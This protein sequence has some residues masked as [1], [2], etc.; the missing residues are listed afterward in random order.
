M[1]GEGEQR[2]WVKSGARASDSRQFISYPR[3]GWYQFAL[4]IDRKKGF[5][6]NCPV[7]VSHS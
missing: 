7:V 4:H 6:R 3:P 1:G 2:W 5:F